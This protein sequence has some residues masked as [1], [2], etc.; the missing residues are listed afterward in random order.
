MALRDV[1]GQD[2]AVTML[3]KTLER[4][5]LPSSYLFT[6]DSGIGKKFT[7][8]NLA[9]AVNCLA[10]VP[11][12]GFRF[13]QNNSEHGTQN[14]ELSSVDACDTCPSCRKVSA[15]IHPDLMLISPAGGQI[16]IEEIRS[17]D[18]ILALKAFEG[19]KKVVIVDDAEAMNSF[20]ANAFLKTLEEPPPDSLIILVSSSPDLLPGTIRSRCVPIRF[21]PLSDSA[22]EEVLKKM[23]PLH[24]QGKDK[25]PGR[26]AQEVTH[27]LPE[28]DLQLSTLV[29]LSMGRPGHALQGGIVEERIAFLQLLREMQQTGTDGWSSKDEMERWFEFTL[30]LLRDMAVWRVNGA[31]ALLINRDLQQYIENLSR[32][33][34]LQ[35]I[36]EI[37]RALNSIRGHF[38][39]HLNKALTWNY[40]GSLLRKTFGVHNA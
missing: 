12:S 28:N 1:V 26:P 19:R 21:T 6:G 30:I 2:R 24:P 39:F 29:R 13:P 7:A 9:K 15:G 35:G 14:F 32:E 16:R 23:T 22:C 8:L 11:D 4:Q 10:R 18:A 31:E 37:Y 5:R 17:I 38:R 40:A 33:T 34:D 27:C 25:K 20:A 36:I 3:R